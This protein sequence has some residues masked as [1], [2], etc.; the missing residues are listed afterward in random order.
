MG[1]SWKSDGTVAGTMMVATSTPAAASYPNS[2]INAG[3]CSWASDGPNLRA[4]ERRHR[5]RPRSSCSDA[6]LT[7]E[8]TLFFGASDGSN[9]AELWKSDG[10]AAEP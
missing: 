10:T 6:N 8:R 7:S 9:G 4:V 3:R 1:G 2:L 5:R